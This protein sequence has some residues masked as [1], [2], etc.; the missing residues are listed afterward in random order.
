MTSGDQMFLFVCLF[1]LGCAANTIHDNTSLIF[2]LARD[3]MQMSLYMYIA[4]Q[5]RS[6]VQDLRLHEHW[7]RVIPNIVIER[8]KFQLCKLL[9]NL[10]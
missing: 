4:F 7:N 8:F 6:S 2:T 3:K 9:Q 1:P 5:T 10:K